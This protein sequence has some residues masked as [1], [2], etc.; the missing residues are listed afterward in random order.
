MVNAGGSGNL[1]GR[2]L[3]NGTG[4]GW[5]T[6]AANTM[7]SMLSGNGAQAAGTALG[8]VSQAQAHNRGTKL[9]AM[10][11]GDQ[12]KAQLAANQR[13]EDQELWK[14]LQAADYMKR[15]GTPRQD[16][17]S[18]TGMKLPSYNFGPAP[19]SQANKDMAATMEQQLL[20][21]LNNPLKPSDYESQMDPST[22][23]KITDYTG[24]ALSGLGA[25]LNAGQPAPTGGMTTKS[26][27]IGSLAGSFLGSYLGK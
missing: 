19:I 1:A 26:Q 11:Q 16:N 3:Q 24:A 14:M 18:S 22:G 20:Q 21:R 25:A 13:A 5:K 2:V 4:A 15:G 10:M 17:Y 23:E 6:T 8:A 9:D 27:K 12:T 7:K